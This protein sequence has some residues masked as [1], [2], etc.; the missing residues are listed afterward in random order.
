M[1][2]TDL[3]RPS[4]AQVT[5]IFDANAFLLKFIIVYYFYFFLF[6]LILYRYADLSFVVRYYQNHC[7]IHQFFFYFL[8]LLL[9]LSVFFF[10]FRTRPHIWIQLFFTR[11]FIL[12]KIGLFCYGIFLSFVLYFFIHLFGSSGN[13]PV[14]ICFVF[15]SAMWGSSYDSIHVLFHKRSGF[16]INA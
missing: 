12:I 10:F 6:F 16:F 13:T 9:L 5:H 7:W 11:A 15:L 4:L 14:F 2:Q 8:V 3:V 1:A